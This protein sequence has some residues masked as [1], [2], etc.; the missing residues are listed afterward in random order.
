MYNK[1]SDAGV[2]Q[3]CLYKIEKSR[4][5]YQNRWKFLD[6]LIQM[7]LAKVISIWM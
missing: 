4:F 7:L 2:F 6:K 3:K 5:L 1:E